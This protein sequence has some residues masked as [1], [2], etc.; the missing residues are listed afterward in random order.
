MADGNVFDKVFNEMVAEFKKAKEQ[1]AADHS[2]YDIGINVLNMF[3]KRLG[4]AVAAE[5]KELAGA[6]KDL[7]KDVANASESIPAEVSNGNSPPVSPEI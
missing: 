1:A 3:A 2:A 6:V 5:Q 4:D 7:A